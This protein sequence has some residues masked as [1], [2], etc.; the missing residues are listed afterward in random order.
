MS[1]VRGR[2]GTSGQFLHIQHIYQVMSNTIHLAQQISKF[3]FVQSVE[4]LQNNPIIAWRKSLIKQSLILIYWVWHDNQSLGWLSLGLVEFRVGLSDM[5]NVSA[6]REWEEGTWVGMSSG[7][8]RVW[9]E[10][11][12]REGTCGY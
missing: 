1:V 11:S 12:W 7:R 8:T 2:C 3:H 5:G 10:L 4:I 6:R 9:L